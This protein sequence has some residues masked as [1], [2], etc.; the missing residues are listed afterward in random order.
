MTRILTS[1]F[2]SLFLFLYTGNSFGQDVILKLKPTVNTPQARDYTFRQVVD[3]R[4]Q[5]SIGQVYDPQ[6]NKHSASFGGNLPQEALQLYNARISSTKN[7]SYRI[8]VK[9]YKLDLKEIYHP[10]L[11][12]Y[13]GDIQLSLGFFLYG[14]KETIHL[15]DFN[16]KVQYGRPGTQMHFVETSLQKLFESSWEYFDSW[17]S[18]QYLTNR[19]LVK[20][21]RLNIIDP[22]RESSKD[23]VFYDPK[24]PLTW[25]DFTETPNPRSSYNATIFSSISIEG[26][27]KIENGEIVQTISVK[28]YMLPEQ[29]WV[30]DANDYANNHEQRHFD[31]TRIAADRMISRL[32]N[33][34]LEPF[35]FEATLNDIYLDAYREMNRLQELYDSQTRN[36]INSE[37]QADW[38]QIIR[39]ALAGD[40]ESFDKILD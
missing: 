11:K 23:T 13:K 17:L 15:V 28:V 30:K 37:K 10:D 12:G 27:A 3:S 24:R 9:V 35:L 4:D 34:E 29:S 38:N 40:M 7:P 22:I 8:L 25:A 36:G 39:K 19:A 5:K 2:L 18:T 26:N 16:S 21:V 32:K 6:R 14:E 33:V 1:A 31:L 20:K